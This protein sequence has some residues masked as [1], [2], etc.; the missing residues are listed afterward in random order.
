MR[1]AAL[2]RATATALLVSLAW[3]APAP[4]EEAASIPAEETESASAEP[5]ASAAEDGPY[6]GVE[7]YPVWGL[8][9]GRLAPVLAAST[10]RI[11]VDDYTAEA[12]GLADVLSEVEG[13]NV[14]RFGGPGDRS[15]LS[16][17]GSSPSQVV[18]TVDG[19]RANSVLTGGLDLSR[20]CLPLLDRIEVTRGAGST[21]E[22]SGAIG[23]VVNLVSRGGDVRRTT[24]ASVEGGAFETVGGSLLHADRR[25]RF[26]YAIGY[27]GFETRGDFEFQRP[28][29]ESDDGFETGFTPDSATR[30]NNDRVQ[31]GANLSLGADLG[32]GTLRLLDVASY[33]SGGEPGVDAGPGPTAGQQTEARSRDLSNLAQL[34]WEGVSP[35]G[36]GDELAVALFH[37]FERERFRNPEVQLG[38]PID[39]DTRLQAFGLRAD[40]VWEARLAGLPL[41][42]RLDLDVLHESIRSS[43]RSGR[44]RPSVAGAIE[45]RL[46]LFDDRVE[47][48]LAGRLDWTD[49]FDPQLLPSVGLVVEPLAWLRL[50]A[51]AGRAYRAPGFDELY[52][53]D[54]GFL[55]GNPDLSPE[56]AWNVDGGVELE[57]AQAGPF[58]NLRL[59][60]TGFYREIDD[61]IVWVLVDLRTI[62]PINTGSAT[63]RGFEASASIDW[64]RYLRLSA[65]HT[66]TDS[67]RDATGESL[68]G[69][70]EHETFARLRLGPEKVWK[71]VGEVQRL[72]E[73]QVNEGGS[74]RLPSRVVWNASA[75][76]N[77]S[78]VPFLP[79]DRFARELWIFAAL[80]NIGDES[81]RDAVSFPQ[82]G[83][84]GR[85][86][87]EVRW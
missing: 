35:T 15:E 1:R 34:R 6:E 33:G 79:F 40:D 78:A 75:S 26:D 45:E 42:T 4:A 64:T 28:V 11:A 85:A 61:S 19:I 29:F 57:L 22:G 71:L 86:G 25:G 55:R 2:S 38:D 69:V 23:G 9:T 48:S 76:L 54:E 82:P 27:C 70:P 67:E 62:A 12:K 80:D 30:L 59:R 81:V 87:V 13:V 49:G 7:E 73:I 60:A 36:W 39:V 41:E 24:R 74:Y 20:L 21:R 72:S 18:V 37:R 52:H 56:D 5:S 65:N 63:T 83:R 43:D 16:I 31:H 51:Q 53:P 10:D 47:L 8:R 50:R 14:R 3:S 46:G 68:S 44:D 66:Y 77:L 58:S 32:P 84:N 17:R